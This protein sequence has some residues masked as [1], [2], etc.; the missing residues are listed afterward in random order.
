MRKIGGH[1]TEW[2]TCSG[3]L[4]NVCTHRQTELHHNKT[5]YLSQVGYIGTSKC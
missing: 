2:K 3:I 1:W 5:D 4:Q